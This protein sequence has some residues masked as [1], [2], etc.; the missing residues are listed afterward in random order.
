MSLSEQNENARRELKD[1]AVASPIIR[2]IR[3]KVRLLAVLTLLVTAAGFLGSVHRLLE[4]TSHFRLQYLAVSL[5][6]WAGLLAFRDWRWSHVGLLCV[7]LNGAV[8]V[9]WYLDSSHKEA[10]PDAKPIRVMVANVLT[11]NRNSAALLTLVAT[12][13]PDLL[14]LQEIDD[15]W[16]GE[17]EVLK[18]KFPYSKIIPRSDNFGIGLWCRHPLVMA[19]EVI[20][21]DAEVPSILAQVKI[22]DQVISILTTHPLP[23]ASKEGFE[24]RNEQLAATATLIRQSSAPTIL[25]GDLNVT[26]WSPYYSKFAR[27]SGLV[28]ARRGFGILP[29][30]PTQLPILKIPLDHCLVSPSIAVKGVRTGKAIGS[31][32]L[33]LIADLAIPQKH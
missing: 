24:V 26:M 27:D 31:D 33:P 18:Q 21:S 4:L 11:S 7:L 3:D 32:H 1:H 5:L 16:A 9:P 29:T 13:S 17:L 12:E 30:W 20:L 8:I 10:G 22:A 14:A 6:C 15:Y 19:E 23:P 25:L 28:N 2:I